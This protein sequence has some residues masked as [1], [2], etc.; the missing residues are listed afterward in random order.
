MP[1]R[2]YVALNRKGGVGKTSTCFHV[3]GELARRGQ[4]VLLI[5]LDPQ[6]N[7]TDKLLMDP[8]TGEVP[9]VPYERTVAALFDPEAYVE[10]RASLVQPTRHARIAVLSGAHRMEH[11]NMG[12]PAMDDRQLVLRDFVE[13]V[14]EQ[15][16][17]I[18]CDCPPNIMIGSWAAMAAGD[19]VI[20]PL[21]AEDFGAMGLKLLNESL[22]QVRRECNP[23][24]ALLGYLLMMYDDKSP[25]HRAYAQTIR[26]SYPGLVLETTVPVSRDLK[27]A[28]TTGNPM[29][30]FKPRCKA[31]KVIQ[32][33]CDELLARDG[34]VRIREVA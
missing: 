23:R 4:R 2:T 32:A 27:M 13:D 1:A 18:I 3:G 12:N 33:L 7:L 11:L 26:D 15:F 29:T 17:F 21:Q 24:L 25:L 6:R 14:R 30:L 9:E 19:G 10:D 22:M 34:A 31:A 16:D 20:V 8:A 5:D 28:V